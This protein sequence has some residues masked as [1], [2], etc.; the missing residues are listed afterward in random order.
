MAD[1]ATQGAWMHRQIKFTLGILLGLGTGSVA[2]AADMA[3][4]ARPVVPPVMY[5]WQGCYV[6]GNV[7]GASSRFDTTRLQLD[8]N[9]PTPAYLDYGRETDSGF[10]GG[11]QAGCDFQTTNWVFGIQGSS[12]F[13]NVKGSHA[14]VNLPG[15]TESNKLDQI[16]TVSGRIG[17]LWTPQLLT[18][19]KVGVAYVRNRNQVFFPGGALFESSNRFYDPGVL[20]GAG[21]EWMF[22]PN[23]SVFVEGSYIWNEDDS[24]AHDYATPAGVPIEVI[25]NRQ[26]IIMG[27]A[28]INYRFNWGGPVVAKY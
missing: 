14:I 7:G 8:T 26:R 11:V 21:I 2:M 19:G 6:G 3:V 20:A 27:L 24:A 9:P 4:K 15:F 5:N 17:Y 25:N 16:Y 12:D 10:I 18:Y 22:A 1:V 13:G 23:W 28:G